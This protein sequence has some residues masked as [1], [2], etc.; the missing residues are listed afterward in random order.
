MGILF[1]SNL[2]VIALS[3]PLSFPISRPPHWGLCHQTEHLD[4][5]SRELLACVGHW[6]FLHLYS[7]KASSV[8]IFKQHYR[9]KKGDF[10]KGK[11]YRTEIIS[12]DVTNIK[13]QL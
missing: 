4:I 3:L 9:R 2:P 6:L 10:L 13:R 5:E 11:C 7:G 8:A 1:S 12:T